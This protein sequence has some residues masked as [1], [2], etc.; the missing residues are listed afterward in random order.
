MCI[1]YVLFYIYALNYV[2]FMYKHACYVYIIYVYMH[3][4]VYTHT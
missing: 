1:L 2:H 3:Y 4:I